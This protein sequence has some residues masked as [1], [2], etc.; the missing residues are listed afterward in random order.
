MAEQDRD[1]R[2]VRPE[3]VLEHVH[4]EALEAA[5]QRVKRGTAL[6]ALNLGATALLAHRAHEAPAIPRDAVDALYRLHRVRVDDSELRDPL[7]A[8]HLPLSATPHSLTGARRRG[9]ASKA[10]HRPAGPARWALD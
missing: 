1:K 6:V 8:T 4:L 7:H 9:P 5:T 10:A 3:R 2:Q